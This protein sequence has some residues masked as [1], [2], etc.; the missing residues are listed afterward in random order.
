[1]TRHAAMMIMEIPI[2]YQNW[3]ARMMTAFLLITTTDLDTVPDDDVDEGMC[4]KSLNDYHREAFYSKYKKHFNTVK[5]D[6]FDYPRKVQFNFGYCKLPQS[7]ERNL[8]FA[9]CIGSNR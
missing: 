9:T 8:Y 6:S 7:R 3:I 5:R 2:C 4:Q 1:M